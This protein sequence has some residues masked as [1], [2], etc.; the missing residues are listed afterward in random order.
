MK[1]QVSLAINQQAINQ[2]PM[3][4][5]RQV[6]AALPVAIALLLAGC[7][8]TPTSTP[9]SETGSASSHSASPQSA[10]QVTRAEQPSAPT[11][12][13]EQPSASPA[14]ATKNTTDDQEAVR[15]AVLNDPSLNAALRR[16][17]ERVPSR[18][19]ELLHPLQV[20]AI[21]IV[22]NYALAEVSGGV[23]D[24]PVIDG[25][26]LLKKQSGQWIVV[27]SV[28]AFGGEIEIDRMARLGLSESTIQGLLDAMRAI[29]A[30]FSI[31]GLP[32]IPRS[33]VV[34][35][36]ISTEMTLA[37]VKQRL[38]EPLSEKVEETGCCGVLVYLEYPTLSLGLVE[39]ETVFSMSTTHLEAP[40]GAGVRV[41]DSHEAVTQAYGPPSRSDGEMLIYHV[42]GSGQSESFSFALE[43]GRVVEIRYYALLN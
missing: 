17:F 25:Y 33:Q 1:T 15:R 14:T 38:G 23:G 35:G 4:R 29:G 22:E 18:N 13:K 8:V 6:S 24:L 41:G 16:E 27:D 19:P 7:P 12:G 42:E 39:D 21:A 36:G 10:A 3:G 37:E 5:L 9:T 34:L 26:Y 30:N 32:T 40:T 28:G 31:M 2:R 20:G 43:G 11:G